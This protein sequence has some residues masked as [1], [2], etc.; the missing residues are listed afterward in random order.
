MSR[1]G[2]R[3]LARDVFIYDLR[4]FDTLLGGLVLTAGVTNA[5][6]Y[7]MVDIV[8]DISPPGPFILQD[9]NGE[10]IAQDAQPLLPGRYFVVADGTVK[11]TA[12]AAFT[13]MISLQ[14]GTRVNEFRDKV[15]QRDG[16]CVVTKEE[17]INKEFDE[18]VGFEAAHIFPL[19]YE[20]QWN[21]QGWSQQITILPSQRS[22]GTINSVQNGLLLDSTVHQ[23]FDSYKFSIN[24]DDGYK[25]ICFQRD[26]KRIAGTSL[27]NRLLQDPQRPLA[28]LLR[29]HFRQAVLTNMKG[30]GEPN[31]EH[32]FPPG[33]DM[34]GEIQSGPKAAE[35]MEFE[36]FDRL[37]H[38]IDLYPEEK[39]AGVDTDEEDKHNGN[40]SDKG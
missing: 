21:T 25:I 36:L 24:P 6:F 31:F 12:E 10:T 30:A 2:A 7:A 38:H 15:R 17:N 3:A 33:S 23:L 39:Q 27:D 13:R 18:W 35:R 11:K 34:M 37:A 5:N 14:S 16:R 1:E 8:I 32:D 28:T 29:W 26:Q 19:A 40:V 4:D 22:Y 9:E 20:G